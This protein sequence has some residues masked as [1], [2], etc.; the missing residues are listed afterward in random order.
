MA[1]YQPE[2]TVRTVTTATENQLQLLTK[3]HNKAHLAIKKALTLDEAGE[4][5]Q[6]IQLYSE[7][8][9]NLAK[10]LEIQCGGPACIGSEFESAKK[11][12]SQMRK[13]AR[14][15]KRRLEELEQDALSRQPQESR[16]ATINANVMEELEENLRLEEE[17]MD[18]EEPPS[19]EQTQS[20]ASE[21]FSIPEGVQI[22]FINAQ[23][24]V[25]APSHPGPLRIYKFKDADLVDVADQPPAFLQVSDW[26]YPLI[27]GESPALRSRQG[28]FLFPDVVSGDPGACVGVMF[29]PEIDRSK[30]QTF[31]RTIQELTVL[32]EQR[33][34][35][36]RPLPPRTRPVDGRE[37][38]DEDE[39]TVA[40]DGEQLSTKIAKGIVI[41][42]EWITWGVGKGAEATGHLINYG[43]D[44]LKQNLT[45]DEK[46]AKIDDKYHTG[47]EYAQK[48]SV[49][50]V[51]VSK[52]VVDSLCFLTKRLGQEVSPYIK[53]Q[54]DK[55]LKSKD[56]PDG[57]TKRSKTMDGVIEVASSSLQGFG[58]VYN[59]LEKAAKALAKNLSNATVDVVQHKYGDDAARLTDTSL[60]AATNIGFT[61]YN[62]NHIGVKAIAKRAAKDTGKAVFEDY[63]A[64]S[65]QGKIKKLDDQNRS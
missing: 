10:G 15:M 3:Y 59:G 55:L 41:G 17:M 58:T 34:P 49:V 43:K 4:T 64:E 13:T 44:K 60:D 9:I 33:E 22:F 38:T 35:P 19:Y 40:K 18:F 25:S 29:A 1:N 36:A 23:G 11:M 26:L 45:T 14:Q 37:R 8:L 20:D 50:A 5:S 48:A 61:A 52:A 7:G 57:A 28:A 62:L 56:Q 30:I 39:E 24:H 31:E 46:P 32:R 51:K 54:S 27:P 63:K 2:R 16:G 47:A 21:V 65:Q 12:Q 42:A 6:A 53:K